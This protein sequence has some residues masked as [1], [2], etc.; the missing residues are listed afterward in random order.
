MFK[1]PIQNKKPFRKVLFIVF[2][3]FLCQKTMAITYYI[4]DNSV[5]D[6]LF[7]KAIGNDT[8]DGLTPS[9]P[10]LSIEAIYETAKEGD[11]IYID[12]GIYPE[13]QLMLL[14]ENKRKIQIIIAPK[15]A[16]LLDKKSIPATYKTNPSEFYIE[17]DKP[18]DRSLYLQ[19]KRN[20][21]KKS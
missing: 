4:N 3:L 13:N 5:V 15:K 21:G 17:N 14:K 19:H 2:V 10:K 18:V 20:E 8:N 11:V 9:T 7:T 6:D 16:E 12:R 1:L